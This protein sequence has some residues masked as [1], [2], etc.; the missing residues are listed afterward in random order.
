ML[1]DKMNK[2]QSNYIDSSAN[3]S[4]MYFLPESLHMCLFWIRM[5]QF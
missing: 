2:L 4:E 3:L 5:Q 1:I